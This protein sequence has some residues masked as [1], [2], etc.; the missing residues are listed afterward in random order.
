MIGVSGE[1]K[2]SYQIFCKGCGKSA[3]SRHRF[4]L[5]NDFN[6]LALEEAIELDFRKHT[7]NIP[8][9]WAMYGRY[10]I[11]C[12]TCHSSKRASKP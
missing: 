9:D 5:P 3:L 2:Y 10:N 6:V 12:P 1:I 4:E 7:P 11:F 8:V